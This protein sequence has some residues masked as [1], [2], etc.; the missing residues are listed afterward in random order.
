MHDDAFSDVRASIEQSIVD[1]RQRLN[2]SREALGRARQRLSAVQARLNAPPSQKSRSW[3][4]GIAVM[5][6]DARVRGLLVRLLNLEGYHAFS[7]PWEPSSLSRIRRVRPG[8]VVLDLDEAQWPEWYAARRLQSDESTRHIPLLVLTRDPN[9]LDQVPVNVA[10][11]C[12]MVLGPLDMRAFLDKV[13][14]LAPTAGEA[15][16]QG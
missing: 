6:R 7:C 11:R 15:D 8:L 4:R 12:E 9:A 10:A 1:S 5:H 2:S 3:S 16:E 13:A 14:T